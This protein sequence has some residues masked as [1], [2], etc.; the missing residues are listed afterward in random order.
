[1]RPQ[2]MSYS[3]LF[4]VPNTWCSAKRF[5]PTSTFETSDR[6][7]VWVPLIARLCAV[8]VLMFSSFPNTGGSLGVV[9]SS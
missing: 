6:E 2:A 7:K 4:V 1:M 3:D 9:S 5:H 8:A